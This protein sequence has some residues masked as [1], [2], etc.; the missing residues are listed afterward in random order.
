ML[1]KRKLQL[2][3]RGEQ[4]AS[5][6]DVGAGDALQ[7][8]GTGRFQVRK[9]S[10]LIAFAIVLM[11]ATTAFAAVTFNPADG[12]GFVGKGDVQQALGLNNAQIQACANDLVFTYDCVEEY[13]LTVAREQETG[14]ET[15]TVTSY[16]NVSAGIN[17]AVEYDARTKK[18]VTGFIL[19]GYDGDPVVTGEVPV[20]GDTWTDG[21]G[22]GAMTWEVVAVSAEGS[23]G[24]LLVNGVPLQ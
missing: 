13:S 15:Q 9:F 24:G 23:S 18:Q 10:I 14:R 21:A 17:A 22:A 4:I 20:V 11:A 6:W 3:L 1:S 5:L 7:L 8:R 2:N 12:T 16:R 19:N